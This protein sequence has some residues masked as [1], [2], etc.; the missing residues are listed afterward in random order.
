MTTNND[1][2]KHLE[3]NRAAIAEFAFQHLSLADTTLQERFGDNTQSLWIDYFSNR[4]DELTAALIAGEPR[5]FLSSIQWSRQAMQARSLASDDL[6]HSVDC[7]RT[8]LLQYVNTSEQSL[9]NTYLEIENAIDDN[10]QPVAD[11]RALDPGSHF[12]RIA[13]Q[14][15][16]SVVVG[17]VYA[18]MDTV[19]DQVENGLSVKEAYLNVLLPAQVEVGRLWHE[20]KLSVA[21][22]HLVTTTTHRLMAVLAQMEQR[23]PDNGMTVIAAAVSGNAHELGIRTIAYLLEFDGWKTIYLGSDVPAADLPVTINCFNADVVLLSIG[24]HAQVKTLRKTIAAIRSESTRPTYVMVGGNGFT[25]APDLWKEVGA[26]GFATSADQALEL[27]NSLLD[28][29]QQV[30]DSR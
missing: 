20:N 16:Q 24:L 25:G 10:D 6:R 29:R 5:I 4:V 13:L 15:L 28:S 30:S 9:I 21:E 19:I 2:A 3:N 23:E 18:G 22:E 17:N 8:A 1:V 11:I 7:F 26:D 12:K 27:A 14:Y